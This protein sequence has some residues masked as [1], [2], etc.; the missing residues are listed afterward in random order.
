MMLG[1]KGTYHKIMRTHC[2][3]GFN[4]GKKGGVLW[5]HRAVWY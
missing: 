1:A 3:I 2:F 4:Q 5:G